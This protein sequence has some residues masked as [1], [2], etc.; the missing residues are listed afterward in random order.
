MRS[1]SASRP[2][3]KL[4]YKQIQRKARVGQKAAKARRLREQ[5]DRLQAVA[6]AMAALD[7]ES[8]A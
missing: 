5:A 7:E 3:K 8:G 2:Q 1:A 6:D 4:Y